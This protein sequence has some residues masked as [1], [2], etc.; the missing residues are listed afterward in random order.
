VLGVEVRGFEPL[1][2]SVRE[3]TGV[4]GRLASAP[5]IGRLTWDDD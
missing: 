1:T 5:W 3:R 4:P 2:S